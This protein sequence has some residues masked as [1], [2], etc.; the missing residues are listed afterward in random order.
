MN[1]I[2]LVTKLIKLAD[3][4]VGLLH[5]GYEF[6]A[7]SSVEISQPVFVWLL[8]CN[9]LLTDVYGKDSENMKT[10][11]RAYTI[12]SSV[13]LLVSLATI[14]MHTGVSEEQP[15]EENSPQNPAIF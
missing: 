6:P 12:R 1:N 9:S 3:E 5:S 8:K 10:F 14:E 13:N 4:G 2:N 11:T 15:S 7:S